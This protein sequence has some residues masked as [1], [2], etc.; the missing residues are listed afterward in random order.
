MAELMSF[1]SS[2]LNIYEKISLQFKHALLHF[3]FLFSENRFLDTSFSGPR[4]KTEVPSVTW[5]GGNQVRLDGHGLPRHAS[6]PPCAP[7][8]RETQL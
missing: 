2:I 4:P 1:N 8:G 3:N 7:P 5:Y 6:N